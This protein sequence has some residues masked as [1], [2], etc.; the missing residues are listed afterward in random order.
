MSKYYKLAV[1]VN[2]SIDEVSDPLNFGLTCQSVGLH[3]QIII[4]HIVHISTLLRKIVTKFSSI[5]SNETL[6]VSTIVFLDAD[7]V[8]KSIEEFVNFSKFLFIY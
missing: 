2:K 3:K 8:L 4:F 5:V 6:I 7:L 1:V